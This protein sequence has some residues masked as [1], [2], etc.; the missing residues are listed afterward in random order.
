MHDFFRFDVVT[1]I[2]E[3]LLDVLVSIRFILRL[4]QMEPVFQIAL[5]MEIE[6]V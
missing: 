5:T 1:K 3:L 6:R 4:L 2:Y